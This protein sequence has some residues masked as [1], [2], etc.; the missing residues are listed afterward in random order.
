MINDSHTCVR[1]GMRLFTLDPI[2]YVLFLYAAVL[3]TIQTS[4]I[5]GIS[6][7]KKN[8]NK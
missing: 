1:A 8:S 2:F 5:G 4:D 7:G 6:N 3:G